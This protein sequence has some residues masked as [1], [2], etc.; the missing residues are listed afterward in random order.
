M[1]LPS[2]SR[3]AEAFSVVGMTSPLALRGLSRALRVT[4]LL[5]HL[6][7]GGGELARLLRADERE[8][9]CSI[10]S[11]GRKPSSWETASLAWRIL[12]SRSET[13][14][15]SGAFLIRLSA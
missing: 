13:N 15:G 10:S 1:T 9:D 14:T 3:R 6:A 2:G 7:Q 11:S 5:D 4:P 12:P 8:S